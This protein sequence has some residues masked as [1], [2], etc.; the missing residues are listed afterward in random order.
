MHPVT[1]ERIMLKANKLP[2]FRAS[3]IFKDFLN[4]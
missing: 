1:K 2:K 4:E 3:K